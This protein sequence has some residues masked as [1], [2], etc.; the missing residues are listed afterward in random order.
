[1]NSLIN[2]TMVRGKYYN[3]RIGIRRNYSFSW[4]LPIWQEFI[5]LHAKKELEILTTLSSYEARNITRTC[6]FPYY[7]KGENKNIL[8]HN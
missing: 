7:Y 4:K 2:N 1:M 5:S 6:S 8:A 3:L